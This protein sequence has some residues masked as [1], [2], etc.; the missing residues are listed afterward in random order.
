MSALESINIPVIDKLS[1]AIEPPNTL[2]LAGSI[3]MRDPNAE[4]GAF[5]K[6]V[7][8]AAI[9]DRVA[10]VRVN[11]E[12]LSFVSSSALRIFVDWTTW[13]RE[14]GGKGYHLKFIANRKYRWQ[15]ANLNALLSLAKEHVSIE[16]SG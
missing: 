10:E 5:L 14:S 7:H 2:R 11:L 9:A 3:A 6:T 4:V 12:D 15:K 8:D 13:L 16:L 1:I